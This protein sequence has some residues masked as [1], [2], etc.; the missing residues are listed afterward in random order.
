MTTL[1]TNL[2][3]F[4]LH[5]PLVA[6]SGPMTRNFTTIKQLANAGIGA[7]ITKT[8]LLTPS[9]NPQPCLY[10]GKGYFLNTER[11][12]TIPLQRW[13]EEELPRLRELSIPII[14]S[15]GMTPDEVAELAPSVVEAGAQM[16]E[17]SIF[18]G[19]DDPQPM[20][21]AVRRVK[22]AVDVPVLVKLSANLHDIVEFGHAVQKAGADAVSAIDALK[23]GVR[24]DVTTGHPVL[25]QQGFGRISGESIK[26]LALYNVAQL[27]HYVGIPII[28]TGGV[29]SGADAVEMLSCGAAAVG[30][31]TALIL[32][33]PDKATR[34]NEQI[35][36]FMNE[37]GISSLDEIRGRTLSQ[38]DFPE[39]TEERQEYEKRQVQLTDQAAFIDQETC[40]KCGVCR[41]VCLY[42]A[43]NEFDGAF[44]IDPARCKACGLCVSMCPVNAIAYREKKEAER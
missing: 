4:K 16:L 26:P 2:L 43:V 12:S 17:L 40:I 1:K 21:E 41:R 38:I 33:G 10:R 20:V 19:Y 22:S 9:T 3:G 32:D 8:I 15:I 42:G 14:A 36:D 6:A 25:L 24:V 44:V 29:T 18:T 13:L 28:G 5:S 39:A 11:C 37:H 23:A 35:L 31:C 27:A 34:M 7:A 30:V